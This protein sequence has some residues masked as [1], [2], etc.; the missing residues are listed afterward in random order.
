MLTEIIIGFEKFFMQV[1]G[2]ACQRSFSL[3]FFAD[4][5]NDIKIR[6]I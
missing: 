3:R 4:T 1:V 6:R 5:R 2:S